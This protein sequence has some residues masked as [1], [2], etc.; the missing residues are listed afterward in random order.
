M[1]NLLELLSTAEGC[2]QSFSE[3]FDDP[4]ESLEEALKAIREAIELVEAQ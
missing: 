4:Q 1:D 3:A 2:V